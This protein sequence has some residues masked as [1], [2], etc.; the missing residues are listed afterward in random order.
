MILP[1][2]N[3]AC[4]IHIGSLVFK[5]IESVRIFESAV[6]IGDRAEITLPKEYKHL[7]GKPVLDYLK[8][9]DPV[10]IMLGYDGRLET[11]FTG[12]VSSPDA[13]M[14]LMLRCDDA[15]YPLKQNNWVKVYK[16]VTLKKLLQDIAPGYT[17]DCPAVDLG[18]IELN[19]VSTFEVLTNMQQDYGLFARIKDKTLV[20]GYSWDWDFSKTKRHIYHRQ[21]NVRGDKLEWKRETDLNVRVQV[22]VVDAKGKKQTIK[23]GSELTHAS[24]VNIDLAG[25][26][27]QLAKDVARARYHKY[28]YEGFTGNVDGWGLP[29]THAGD[30]LEYQDDF[31]PEKNSAYLIERVVIDYNEHDGWK[32]SNYLAYKID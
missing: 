28:V 25:V 6:E 16:T 31:Q 10:T 26:G 14:P 9:G 3:M 18:K 13:N 17:I 8:A 22:H 1:Y 30:S 20:V 24:V 2:F 29:R 21:K 23:Y 5:S 4:E 27:V 19:N 32:R 11:E 7:K 15:F 12:F